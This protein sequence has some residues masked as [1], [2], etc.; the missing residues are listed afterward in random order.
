M[1]RGGERVGRQH[2][3]RSALAQQA[4]HGRQRADGVVDVLQDTVAEHQIGGA[5]REKLSQ[6]G[7]VALQRPHPHPGLG[8]TALQRGQR[9][10][11][12]VDDRDGVPELGQRHGE[13]AG[14]ASGVDDVEPPAAGRGHLAG[15]HCPQDVPDDG[16]AD[17]RGARCA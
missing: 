9:V 14:A 4:A 1:Q 15:Q 13:P 7:G 17:R 8:G 3:D 11:A 2:A 6:V 16:G 10:G 5:R 12:G